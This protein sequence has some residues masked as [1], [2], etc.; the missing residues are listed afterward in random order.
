M[1]YSFAM[2]KLIEAS[3]RFKQQASFEAEDGYRDLSTERPRELQL[4]ESISTFLTKND[5]ESLIAILQAV[6]G[7]LVRRPHDGG[8]YIHIPKELA[9]FCGEVLLGLLP[10]Y[11]NGEDQGQVIKAKRAMHN[12]QA[13]PSGTF[14]VRLLNQFMDPEAGLPVMV[15]YGGFT[16]N[17]GDSRL[18]LHIQTLD[19]MY[20]TSSQR[21]HML[22]SSPMHPGSA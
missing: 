3:S 2:G 19:I 12:G 10:A 4:R 6:D 1:V 17:P 11:G 9:A 14:Q 21:Q 7:K 16:K 5:T 8:A 22:A 20:P 13:I 15:G 18:T